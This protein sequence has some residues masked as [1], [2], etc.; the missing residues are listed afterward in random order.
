M[1]G[2]IIHRVP[3]T[4]ADGAWLCAVACR[5]RSIAVL[6]MCVGFMNQNVS[7]SV[8]TSDLGVCEEIAD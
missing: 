8:F 1:C 6:E 3:G 5:L 7:V 2:I 4:L